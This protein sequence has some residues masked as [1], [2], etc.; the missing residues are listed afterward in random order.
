MTLS[1]QV[2]KR[3]MDGKGIGDRFTMK[4]MITTRSKD[5]QMKNRK[6]SPEQRKIRE[7]A[8]VLEEQLY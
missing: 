5:V 7:P 1:V 6:V 8:S 2:N 3:Q 4:K